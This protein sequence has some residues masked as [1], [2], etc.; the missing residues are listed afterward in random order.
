MCSMILQL[1]REEDNI[2]GHRGLLP[3]S[4]QQTYSFQAPKNLRYKLEASRL[5]DLKKIGIFISR[6][7]YDKMI[8]PLQNLLK[9]GPESHH[10]LEVG[11]K[12]YEQSLEKIAS[13]YYNINRFLS[14]FID[15][16]SV[17]GRWT[18]KIS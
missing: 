5:N 10:T 13:V 3:S 17:D 11:H 2:C 15:H 18:A 1:K 9:N 16:V 12:S 6:T 4:E 14:A 8:I 7:L